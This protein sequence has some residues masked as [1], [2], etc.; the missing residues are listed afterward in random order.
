[1]RNHGCSDPLRRVAGRGQKDCRQREPRCDANLEA[2]NTVKYKILL[3]VLSGAGFAS[4]L[5]LLLNASLPVLPQLLSVM[6][7]PGAIPVAVLSKSQ[8]FGPPLAV[9]AANALVYSAV[10]YIAVSVAWRKTAEET[11]RVATIRS[12]LPVAMLI[13]LS[14]VPALNPLWPRGMTELTTQEKELQQALPLGMGLDGVRAVLQS[15]GIQF[16]EE[17]EASQSVVLDDGRGGNI[18]AT[19]GDRV[20]SAR[21]QTEAN[22]FPC[23]YDIQI[24]LLFGQDEKMKQQHVQRL[25]LCP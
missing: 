25:R 2:R 4:L 23:G 3:A 6:L 1:M 13:G 9:L 12:V 5:V 19:P 17:T 8:E 24:V 21:L 10:A 16:R 18:T 7:L 22:Q 20:V 14:C 11:M 15:K